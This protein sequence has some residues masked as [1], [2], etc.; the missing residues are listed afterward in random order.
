[1]SREMDQRQ[2]SVR[3]EWGIRGAA[4][5]SHDAEYAVIV[6]V[7][8]FTTTV[9]VALDQH[10][11]VLPYPWREQSAGDFARRHDAVLAESRP[12]TASLASSN[13]RPISLSPAS[14]RAAGAVDRLVLPSPNGSAIARALRAHGAATQAARP[15]ILAACLRNR[16]AVANWLAH[17]PDPP[18]SVKIV[19]IIAAGERWPDDSLRPAAEDLW[20]AG[21]VI[22]A[23]ACL[24]MSG[25]SPEAQS[26]AAAWQA[27]EQNLGPALA[28]CGSGMELAA[29]GYTADVVIAGELDASRSV[30]LLSRGRFLDASQDPANH[31]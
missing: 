23:L 31:A 15:Q 19:A 16:G 14:I 11:E 20:G 6:D 10:I 28:S 5:V 29:K 1:M 7:L 4:A 3:M 21:A 24:G 18:G 2:F 8:R 26:A 9:S 22:A 30:P 13:Q 12:E 27:I 25:L 17:Q